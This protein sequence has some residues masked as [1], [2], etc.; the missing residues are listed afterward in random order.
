MIFEHNRIEIERAMRVRM[1]TSEPSVSIFTICAF[2]RTSGALVST[3]TV[4]VVC[5][6]VVEARLPAIVAAKVEPR[7]AR[8]ADGEV[9]QTHRPALELT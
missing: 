2:G 5:F 1:S 4:T 6:A 7:Q 3:S 9:M 8:I